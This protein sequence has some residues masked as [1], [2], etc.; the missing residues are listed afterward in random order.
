MGSKPVWDRDHAAVGGNMVRL[1]KVLSAHLDQTV[2]RT[3]IG[4]CFVAEHRTEWAYW[5]P[6]ARYRLR[7]VALRGPSPATRSCAARVIPS[8]CA[9]IPA[10]TMGRVSTLSSNASSRDRAAAF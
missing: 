9:I 6:H 7:P 3:A 8:F 4:I 1:F 10:A 5:I 2:Q